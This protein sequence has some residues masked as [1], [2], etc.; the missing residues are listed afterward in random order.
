MEDGIDTEWWLNGKLH[1][2]DGPAIVAERKP[3]YY[4]H[5]EDVGKLKIEGIRKKY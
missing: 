2:L 4:A 1:K 5:N 3:Q